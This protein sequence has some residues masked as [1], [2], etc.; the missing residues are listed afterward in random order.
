M[1]ETVADRDLEIGPGDDDVG[2]VADVVPL[3]H[4]EVC[5]GAVCECQHGGVGAVMPHG[6]EQRVRGGDGTRQLGGQKVVQFAAT[7]GQAGE[8]AR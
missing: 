6:P 8:V 3:D 2:Q 4:A 7:A 1:A 5:P